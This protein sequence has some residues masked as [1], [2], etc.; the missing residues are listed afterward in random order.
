MQPTNEFVSPLGALARPSGLARLQEHLARVDH[1]LSKDE[2]ITLQNLIEQELQ[3]APALSD[4]NLRVGPTGG[5]GA[6]YPA[7]GLISVTDPRNTPIL[8]HEFGHAKRT[9]PGS[10]YQ[11]VQDLSRKVQGFG[12]SGGGATVRNLAVP[13]A[14]AT[15]LLARNLATRNKVLGT[16]AL[17][18]ALAGA[19]AVFEEAAASLDAYQHA[20]NKGEAFSKLS[21]GLLNYA[22]EAAVP[23][24]AALLLR[25]L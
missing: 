7:S 19:P 17:L 14:L 25:K 23:V 20:P 18:S 3:E 8:A 24:A 4:I 11:K 12:G 22:F 1:Q 16:I 6:Y 2:E 15:T 10:L 9:V 13:A 5:G 21:P